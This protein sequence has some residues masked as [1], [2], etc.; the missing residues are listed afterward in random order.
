[1]NHIEELFKEHFKAG[2]FKLIDSSHPL[3]L[4]IG[5]DEQGHKAIEYR[6]SFK[7]IKLKSTEVVGIEH[8][9]NKDCASIVISLLHEEMLSTFSSLCMDLMDSTSQASNEEE[10]YKI[11]VNRIYAWKKMFVSKRGLLEEKDIIGL[12]GELMYLKEYIVP[13]YGKAKGISCW[14]GSEKTKK[15][16]SFDQTWFE[17]KTIH[18]GNSHVTISSFEQLESDYLGEL[19]VYQLE[20]MSPQYNGINL[21][22]IAKEILGDLDLDE[23]KDLFFQKLIERGFGFESDYN[24]FVYELT[25]CDKY[26]VTSDFPCL[27]RTSSMGAISQVKYDLLLSKIESFKKL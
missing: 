7:P 19:I 5:A 9:L 27:R 2:Y 15:D 14:T 8:R 3:R 17:V 18:S 20:K 13:E 6:G 4:Y 24:Q 25:R 22:K 10:G 12:I 16:F 1:M 23:L 26:Q 11:L 21:N